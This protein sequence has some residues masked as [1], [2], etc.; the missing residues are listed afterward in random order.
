MNFSLLYSPILSSL[1]PPVLLYA[2]SSFLPFSVTVC[3]SLALTSLGPVQLFPPPPSPISTSLRT[4]F[5]LELPRNLLSGPMAQQQGPLTL[6][7][8]QAL[9]KHMG[10]RTLPKTAS[11]NP[12]NSLLRSP[13]QLFTLALIRRNPSRESTQQGQGQMTNNQKPPNGPDS[14]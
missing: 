6:A 7:F 10:F 5:S 11:P 8:A 14:T 12:P 13:S 1:F 3:P 9:M 4:F 2:L